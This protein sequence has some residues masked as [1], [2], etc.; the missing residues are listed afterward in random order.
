MLELKHRNVVIVGASGGLGRCLVEKFLNAGSNVFSVSRTS[1][2]QFKCSQFGEC[3]C[4][5]DSF[6]KLTECFAQIDEVFGSVDILINSIGTFDLQDIFSVT[7]EQYE[8]TMMINSTVPFMFS[9]YYGRQMRDNEFGRIVNVGSS[10]CY[11]GSCDTGAYSISKHA[12]LGMSRS[13]HKALD[14][15]GVKVS[16]VSPGSMQ[17][18]MGAKDTRQDYETFLLPDQVADHIIHI[19]QLNGNIVIEES[20]LKRED[21]GG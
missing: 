17:T 7:P 3:C 15:W 12:L 2:P 18:V 14:P 1:L 11:N 6:S 4:G 9:Q 5:V 21:I 13:M 19:V 16:C 8:K 20:R 10:S